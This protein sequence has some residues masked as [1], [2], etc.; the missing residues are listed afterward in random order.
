MSEPAS[1]K[2]PFARS[3]SPAFAALSLITAACLIGPW[4]SP[5]GHDEVHRDYLLVPPSLA[6]H[7]TKAETEAALAS[8]GQA[9]HLRIAGFEITHS[10]TA[11]PTLRATFSADAPIDSRILRGFTGSDI[12]GEPHIIGQNED[13]RSLSVEAPLRSM[14]FLFGTDANGRDLLTR[15]L[16]AGRISL[17]V[18]LL[19]SLVALVFGVTYGAL[20]GYLGGL[21]GALMMRFVEIVYALPF[22]FLVIVLTMVLGR[23]LALILIAIA[24]VE[25]L[26]MARIVRAQ[27]LSLKHRDFVT[28]SEALGAATPAILWRHILPNAFG[29]IAAYLTILVPRVI[30][31][32]SFVSF[33]GLGVQEPLTSWGVLIADGARTIQSAVHLLVFPSLFLAATLAALNALSEDLRG[34]S[35]RG[36]GDAQ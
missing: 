26:D 29:P 20:A 12:F 7:P 2:T 31:L 18:G 14:H 11:S 27:T 8:I 4:L 24:S 6:A 28:A 10:A 22:I 16:V 32:E 35:G 13:G 34:F 17:A 5:H 3:I 15:V 36:P 1:T 9:L 33:L 30:L 19:A 25:W 23:G 21:T